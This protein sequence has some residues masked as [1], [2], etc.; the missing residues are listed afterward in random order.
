MFDKAFRKAPF[1]RVLLPVSGGIL[2]ARH[3]PLPVVLAWITA[4]TF[5]FTLLLFIIFSERPSGSLFSLPGHRNALL[6]VIF[7]GMFFFAGMMMG[8]VEEVSGFPEL[9]LQA[10]ICEEVQEGERTYKTGLDRVYI[11][12]GQDWSRLD[13]RVQVYFGKEERCKDLRPGDCLTAWGFLQR[14]EDPVNPYEFN[15]GD[16]QHG[17]GLFYHLYLDSTSWMPAPVYTGRGLKIRAKEIRSILMDRIDRSIVGRDEKA[18]LYSLL[19]G[20]RAELGQE[21]RQQ[22]VRSG[23][24]H[25]LAV[26]G[27]HVGILYLLPAFLI[28][29]IRGSMA[30]SLLATLAL[31][32]LLWSYAML[33]GLSPSVVRA[34]S[35]CSIHRMA[36]L[37]GRKADIFHVLSLTAVLMLL[38]RPAVLFEAGFQLSFAAV[39]GIAWFQHPLYKLIPVRGWLARKTW[40]LLTVSLAAQIATAPL[41]MFYF[42]QF[43][44]VFFLSNLVVI[45]LATLI[46]YVGLTFIVLSS[47]GMYPVSGMLEWLTSL[48]GGMTHMMGGIP[49]AY[50]SNISLLPVQVCLL[51]LLI[52]L[53]GFFVHS[54]KVLL[55]HGMMVSLILLLMVSCI[56][57]YRVRS[58]EA[59][60]VFSLPRE[61]AISFVRGRQHTMYRGG[62]MRGDTLVIPYAIR[63]FS[64]RHKL[65]SPDLLSCGSGL[66]YSCIDSGGVQMIYTNFKNRSMLIISQLE[67]PCPSRATSL[68]TDILLLTDNVSCNLDSLIHV[69]KPGLIIVDGS[70]STWYHTWVESACKDH[71][72]PFHSTEKDGFYVF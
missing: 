57:E 34:V 13:G 21:V 45:P 41:S 6:A 37:M 16:Y 42:H 33:T 12:S 17:K 26:S 7:Q 61:S 44:N 19:L 14:Y 9:M 70:S 46:L 54:R 8:R 65:T 68:E 25:I 30:G 18:I 10:R 20:Y 47:V 63:N 56:R 53:G 11:S 28:G 2:M 36:K 58:Q 49:G 15:Y 32:A 72:I 38:S 55:A 43:S 67:N 64:T 52:L 40:Q 60:Y 71:G 24:M 27:L 22:F 3:H 1:M 69:F 50:C 31:L 39:A 59:C 35:M 62:R 4:G 51:Y 48:L 5:I 66:E 29:K 23:S